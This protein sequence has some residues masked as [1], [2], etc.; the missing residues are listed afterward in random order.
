MRRN[1]HRIGSVTE[2]RVS[3]TRGPQLPAKSKAEQQ[4]FEGLVTKLLI[5]FLV[6]VNI[7]TG[8]VCVNHFFLFFSCEK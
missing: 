7:D 3:I 1:S 2:Y 6:T 8:T 4:S 5:L